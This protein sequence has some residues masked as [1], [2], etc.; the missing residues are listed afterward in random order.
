MKKMQT[1]SNPEERIRIP[2]K[3]DLNPSVHDSNRKVAQENDSNPQNER[4]ESLSEEM[5]TRL[6]DPNPPQKGFDPLKKFQTKV[7]EGRKIRISSRKIRISHL[8]N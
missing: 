7:K 5:E 6:R 2:M 4:F 1:D 8:E 3:R